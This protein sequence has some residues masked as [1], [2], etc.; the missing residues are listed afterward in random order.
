[1]K[2][3]KALMN[4]PPRSSLSA[5]IVVLAA[6]RGELVKTS[7][8]GR[9][10]GRWFF[11]EI[12]SDKLGRQIDPEEIH[13][14]TVQA[15]ASLIRAYGEKGQ[16]A[17]DQ[18]IDLLV[19]LIT[20]P[21]TF[22]VIFRQDTWKIIQVAG[23]SGGQ[24]VGQR[25]AGMYLFGK[26]GDCKSLAVMSGATPSRISGFFGA[27]LTWKYGQA[28]RD[29]RLTILTKAGQEAVTAEDAPNVD[30]S[31]YGMGPDLK[32]IH[33]GLAQMNGEFIMCWLYGDDWR[34]KG[35]QPLAEGTVVKTLRWAIKDRYVIKCNAVI[36]WGMP[37][38]VDLYV[39]EENI[40]KEWIPFFD[41]IFIHG[42]VDHETPLRT[43]RQ[44][45]TMC[46]NAASVFLGYVRDFF[47]R[48][49]DAIQGGN[50]TLKEFLGESI[51]ISEEEFFEAQEHGN[52]TIAGKILKRF[53]I[54]Q[55]PQL[56]SQLLNAATGGSKLNQK[57]ALGGVE[58][59]RD[60]A[61]RAYILPE[62][63]GF[64]SD[65][66]YRTSLTSLR[67]NE[68]VCGDHEGEATAMRSPTSTPWEIFIV[69]FVK[70]LKGMWRAAV[71]TA[72]V[73]W[74][75]IAKLLKRLGGGDLD[76]Q[77]GFNKDKKVVEAAKERLSSQT[78]LEYDTEM[79]SKFTRVKEPAK[80]CT[81]L[82][83][84]NYTLKAFKKGML[85]IIGA[86]ASTVC[87]YLPVYEWL[88]KQSL[89][90][91][92]SYA[93]FTKAVEKAELGALVPKVGIPKN[94]PYQ[95]RYRRVTVGELYFVEYDR[96][97]K[98]DVEVPLAWKLYALYSHRLQY[99]ILLQ[100][101]FGEEF[102]DA[103]NKGENGEHW[104]IAL[105]NAICTI[106][107]GIGIGEVYCFAGSGDRKVPFELSKLMMGSFTLIKSQPD[108]KGKYPIYG[109][110]SYTNGVL[111]TVFRDVEDPKTHEVHSKP[112]HSA[113]MKRVGGALDA[114]EALLPKVQDGK[115]KGKAI[116]YKLWED[117]PA[118]TRE[119]KNI[120]KFYQ[121]IW[122]P[123]LATWTETKSIQT[124]VIALYKVVQ[125]WY[126]VLP[127]SKYEW[128]SIWGKDMKAFF[129]GMKEED[130]TFHL[131]RWLG[132]INLVN[133][134]K[135]HLTFLLRRMA[136]SSVLPE[137]NPPEGLKP[138]EAQ[139]FAA[140]TILYLYMGCSL[141]DTMWASREGKPKVNGA[142]LV[143][144]L[145]G[146]DL[147]GLNPRLAAG[148]EEVGTGIGLTPEQI[149]AT[150]VLAKHHVVNDRLLW[151]EEMGPRTAFMLEKYGVDPAAPTDPTPTTPTESEEEFTDTVD[152]VSDE[153]LGWL[154]D[155]SNI[156]EEE[157]EETADPLPSVPEPVIEE[158]VEEMPVI[159]S[160]LPPWKKAAFVL[161]PIAR[162]TDI[163]A[164][165]T[166]PGS[167]KIG[168]PG[169]K[170]EPGDETLADTAVREAFEEGWLVEGI[171]QCFHVAEVDGYEVHWFEAEV[172]YPMVDFKEKGRIETTSASTHE[173]EES[174]MGNMQAMAAYLE[175]HDPAPAEDPGEQAVRQ[176]LEFLSKG[177]NKA[178]LIAYHAVLNGEN[179]VITGNAGSGK[180]FVLS[181]LRDALTIMDRRH[182]VLG[183]TGVSVCNVRGNATFHSF[184]GLGH[185]IGH[186][187][188]VNGQFV[189]EQPSYQDAEHAIRRMGNK[190]SYFQTKLHQWCAGRTAITIIIDEVSMID[191]ALLDVA[192]RGASESGIDIQWV[193]VGDPLQMR[194]VDGELFFK[195]PQY[196]ECHRAVE[197]M[198]QRLSFTKV[199]L[200]E[201][202]RQKDDKAYAE[203]LNEIRVGKVPSSDI[204][205]KRIAAYN[206]DQSKLDKALHVYASKA[207]VQGHNDRA[208]EQ[209]RESGAESYT[210]QAAVIASSADERQALL[211]VFEPIPEFLEIMV[212]MRIMV[213][214]NIKPMGLINGTMGTVTGIVPEMGVYFDTDDGRS[215][216]LTRTEMKGPEGP[217]HAPQGTLIQIPI[218]PA[219][220]LTGHKVQGL[221]IESPMVVHMW[222]GR[223]GKA[224][225]HSDFKGWAYVAL[226]RCT[227][228][229]DLY[230]DSDAWRFNRSIH[231]DADAINWLKT[232]QS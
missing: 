17:R 16:Q 223:N 142:Q 58:I 144:N 184:F 4:L 216:Y 226:S 129:D 122:K 148:I 105:F 147:T 96:Q 38:D 90:K 77:G 166:R 152:L 40:K 28:A 13:V 146:K 125:K 225:I 113:G 57:V 203:A 69:N 128:D 5:T 91:G 31:V 217:D 53:N 199:L 204:F 188:Q 214:Q 2:L 207:A 66:Y 37:K 34:Q 222:M 124:M 197:G 172:A 9:L 174:G 71:G 130:R 196:R 20:D 156:I 49:E 120:S 160:P 136:H 121:L 61:T 36:R 138:T 134:K 108:S 159:S 1:M 220:A 193:L 119:A 186:S 154:D 23:W 180:S 56:A 35:I 131:S 212:G 190:Y 72:Q 82:E 123:N 54:G 85:A 137:I 209:L 115:H 47:R 43:D 157:V 151:E 163:W 99:N 185:G 202:V 228:I 60:L 162:G 158:P 97:Q 75:I 167:D 179:T 189:K 135:A 165:V 118:T 93:E 46:S 221:T 92:L 140:G 73:S 127:T 74:M 141:A 150:K 87:R 231:A 84:V 182:V 183:S 19:P 194:P 22:A 192:E 59:P 116:A 8:E 41:G 45:L 227:R 15:D 106:F 187:T 109:T 68:V 7:M 101:W 48:F 51:E 126:R 29:V 168:L 200:H 78:A 24:V 177:L 88:D 83:L 224:P 80:A 213:R 230:I 139:I 86:W 3:N 143:A 210:F 198:L 205:M 208:I 111:D 100:P 103:G 32:P 39:H 12:M 211:Q 112:V 178:Q 104:I 110:A 95:Q 26:P 52:A 201:I 133:I 155:T 153:D 6:E 89:T 33:D 149:I 50:S 176:D 70:P 102:I 206:K 76:D 30:F 169:G 229:T 132:A 171:G 232:F 164:V 63:A 145:L 79:V 218:V 27:G 173:V 44:W 62:I 107:D 195:P 64:G 98:C 25:L 191:A 219:F 181:R 117:D 170:A 94:T 55:F 10:H 42:I 81:W 175:L 215:V 18:A 21:S 14:I 11:L 65:G 114:V 67:N 161:A